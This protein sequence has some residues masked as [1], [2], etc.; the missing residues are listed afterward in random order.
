MSENAPNLYGRDIRCVR[1]A[2]DLFSEV[3]GIDVV[4]QDAL[5]RIT[6]DDI[7]GGDEGIIVGWGYDVRRLVG[8]PA[9][10]LGA[11]QPIVAEVLTRDPRI[12]SADVTLTATT[13][14]GLA[15]VLLRANCLTALGPFSIVRKVSELTAEDLSS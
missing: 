6:T 5:H 13:T 10:K 3:E 8:M 14:N 4:F 7:L 9:S 1:D 12:Q 11:Q 2:D 15:D